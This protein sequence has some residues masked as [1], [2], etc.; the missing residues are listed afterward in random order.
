MGASSELQIA[1]Q[2]RAHLDRSRVCKSDIFRAGLPITT[3]P[4]SKVLQYVSRTVALM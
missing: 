2:I 1:S 4:Y 3:L